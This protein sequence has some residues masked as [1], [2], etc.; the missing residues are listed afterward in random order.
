MKKQFYLLE[1]IDGTIVVENNRTCLKNKIFDW[2][3]KNGDY[4]LTD[5]QIDCIVYNRSNQKPKYIKYFGKCSF[6]ELFKIDNNI[7]MTHKNNKPFTPNYILA[8]K[9][10]EYNSQY[11]EWKN[12]PNRID[13]NQLTTILSC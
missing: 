5:N 11:N 4:Y 10:K 7:K 6:D 2:C 3:E 12:N 1:F 8:L 9:R 13:R